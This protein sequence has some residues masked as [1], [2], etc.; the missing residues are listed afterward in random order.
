[1]LQAAFKTTEPLIGNGTYIL[2]I[3]D[4]YFYDGNGREIKGITLKYTVKNDSGETAGIE[5]V[6][7]ENGNG[8]TVY[9]ISGIEILK[10]TDASRVEALPAGLYII[11]GTKVYI[12]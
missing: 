1:M 8:W 10:T 3:P 11:N 2:E 4:G 12:K 9:S 7:M 5:D 6:V